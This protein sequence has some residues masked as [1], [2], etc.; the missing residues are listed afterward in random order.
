M[1]ISRV[2]AITADWFDYRY[3]IFGEIPFEDNYVQAQELL[4]KMMKL[5]V[6]EHDVVMADVYEVIKTARVSHKMPGSSFEGRVLNA[7]PEKYDDAKWASRHTLQD[8]HQPSATRSLDYLRENGKCIDNIRNGMSTIPQAGRGAFA[9]RNLPAGTVI[10]A[11]PLHHVDKSFANMYNFTK[12]AETGEYVRIKEQ[13]VGYNLILNYCFAHPDSTIML[14]PYGAGVNYINHNSDPEKVNVR[15]RWAENFPL[16]HNSTA[17]ER[18]PFSYFFSRE[19]PFLAFDYVA[20]KDIPEGSELF[21]DYGPEFAS[22]E[23]CNKYCADCT[24]GVGAILN[25]RSLTSL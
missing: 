13:I 20:I 10:T 14:C 24:V 5:K 22:G 6:S 25:A 2:C 7:L 17:V 21:L 18:A 23:C 9:V 3:E 8:L 19:T 1:S 15:V 16:G 12:S 11:S 4:R